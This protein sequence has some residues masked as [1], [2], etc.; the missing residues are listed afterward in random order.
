VNASGWQ[1]KDLRDSV[2]EGNPVKI[3]RQGSRADRRGKGQ[4]VD[5]RQPLGTANPGHHQK[6]CKSSKSKTEDKSSATASELH[7]IM[8]ENR[9]RNGDAPGAAMM[10]G[11]GGSKLR[12]AQTELKQSSLQA[13]SHRGEGLPVG[14]CSIQ[15]GLPHG[16][17]KS[18]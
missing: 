3:E 11:G 2:E 6:I 4:E 18:S 16:G 9:E 10:G 8:K 12:N 15:G 7:L 14:I 17:A 5:R 13:H 1:D